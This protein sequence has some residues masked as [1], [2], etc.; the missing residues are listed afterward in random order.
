MVRVAKCDIG[1]A[2]A[3]AGFVVFGL[4]RLSQNLIGISQPVSET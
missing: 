3:T 4:V 2:A 1:V